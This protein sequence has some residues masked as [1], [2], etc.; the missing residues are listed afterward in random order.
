MP[1]ILIVEDD[2]A[3]SELV[4]MNLSI[5]GYECDAVYDGEAA[6][7][8]VERH[9]YDLAL[10]DVMLPERDGFELMP[11]MRRHG[12]PVIYVSAR[13]DAA[14]RIQGLRLGAEDY[15]IKPFDIIE[16]RLR[17][18]RVLA[19]VPSRPQTYT[20]AGVCIDEEERTASIDKRYID[21]TPKEFMLMLTLARHPGVAF[22]REQLLRDV[23]GDEFFGETRTVDV[24]ISALRRKLHWQDVIQTVQSYGYRLRVSP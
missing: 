8:A 23:W 22:S 17:V 1:R 14:D 3:I 7:K 24:H 5:A 2:L 15:I 18:E 21:L 20:V 19:R 9:A 6:V 12:V 10:L 13:A 11:A 16:L 4:R